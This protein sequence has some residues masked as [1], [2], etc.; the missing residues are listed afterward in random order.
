MGA[1][2]GTHPRMRRLALLVVML[3][4]L[5]LGGKLG[6]LPPQHAKQSARSICSC[7][8]RSSEKRPAMVK[9]GRA[10][11]STTKLYPT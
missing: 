10:F 9:D 6:A 11:T 1:G 8:A 7:I 5:Y 2:A 4:K 3:L